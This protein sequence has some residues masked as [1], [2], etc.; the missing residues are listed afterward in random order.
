VFAYAHFANHPPEGT[1]PNVVVASVDVALD[2]ADAYLRRFVP[3][4]N[5]TPDEND[6]ASY[7]G[8][9]SIMSDSKRTM[10]KRFSDASRDIEDGEEVW[11]NYRLSTHVEPPAWY[12]RVD[13]E[14]D[15]RRWG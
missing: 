3:N 1:K 13:A 2:D 4:V 15:A 12:T 8:L 14:E 6:E 9:L 10:S 7:E 11:L 5:V